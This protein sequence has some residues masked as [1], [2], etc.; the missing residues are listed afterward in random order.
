MELKDN[1]WI[2]ENNNSWDAN[3]YTQDQAEKNSKSLINCS[4]CSDCSDCTGCMSCSR[5]SDC[6]DCSGCSGCS[7]C[8]GWKANPQKITSPVMGSRNAQTTVYFNDKRTEVICGCFKGSLGEFRL[9]VI[10][11]Y[12]EEHEYIKWINKVQKYMGD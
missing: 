11:K 9:A 4:G 3:K 6:S 8:T 10:A 5:C 7:H 1:K 2:D 12:G